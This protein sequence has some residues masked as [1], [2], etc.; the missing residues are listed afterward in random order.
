[1]KVLIMSITAGEG[2]NSTAKAIA[3]EFAAHGVECKIVDAYR[4]ISPLLYS[5]VSRG[6]LLSVTSLRKI[7][8]GVYAHLEKRRKNAYRHSFTRFIN[9]SVRKKISRYIKEYQPD[10][11]VYT[12]IFCGG[13]LDVI[14]QKEGMTI[15][16][17]GILTDYTMHPYWEE[18]LRT[19]CLVVPNDLVVPAAM[20]KGFKREQ[21][22]PIGIPINPVFAHN[23]EKREA[24]LAV[25]LDPDKK[26]LLVMGGSMGYGHLAD[27][28]KSLD[29]ID[30]DFQ[31]IC[32]CGNNEKAKCA[33][34]ALETKKKL[35]TFGFTD[36]VG[37]LMDASDCIV[38]KPGGLTTSEAMAKRLP[39]II[40]APIPGHEERNTEF[41]VNNGAAVAVTKTYPIDIAVYQ[42]FYHPVRIESMRNCIDYLRRPNAV[43]DIVSLVCYLNKN[44]SEADTAAEDDKKDK[45]V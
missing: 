1:M 12:H 10:A 36:K 25:G 28:V 7:Y 22:Y 24:R 11:I 33:V 37:L 26:T 3:A 45:N 43:K 19:D 42:L 38:T 39:M 23:T 13:I 27:T 15:P 18:A 32:V 40:N 44:A 14:K 21:I 9:G 34:D 20:K 17:V 31:M 30:L 5:F 2:H 35:L 41:F 16:T 6:Y 4:E 8:S 29:A